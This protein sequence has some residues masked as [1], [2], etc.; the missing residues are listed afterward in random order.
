[1]LQVQSKNRSMEEKTM[2]DLNYRQVHLDFHT[3]QYITEIGKNFDAEKFADTLQKA[4]VNSVT[5]FARCHHGLLYYPSRENPELIHPHLKRPGLL[6]EQIEACHKRGIRVPV[7]TTVRW[8]ER[9]L[10]E[11]PEWL[12]RDPEGNPINRGGTQ[13]SHFCY[14]I[15]LN[16]G[17]REFFK[18]HLMDI[19]DV[20]G[21]ENLDGLFMDIVMQT[22]CCCENCRQLMKQEGLN[23]DIRKDRIRFAELTL[24]R[25][26]SEISAFIR[27]LAPDAS[28]FYNDPGIDPV[29]KRSIDTYSHLELESLPSGDWGY[30]HFPAM[31]RYASHFGKKMIGMTGKFHTAWGDFHSLK[32]KEA[33]E[34]E[35]FQMLAMGTGCSVGDQLHPWG[36]LS[37]AT[38][39]LIG[40]V[41]GRIEAKEP[42]CKGAVMEAEAAVL[43]PHEYLNPLLDGRELP[44]SL[45]GAVH[46]LQELSCQFTV[47]DSKDRFDPYK[48]LILPD[49]IPYSSE[50][51]QKLKDYVAG[52]GAVFGSYHACVHEKSSLYGMQNI[53]E[54][55][56]SREFILPGPVIGKELPDEPFVMYG[57]GTDVEPA[58][59]I[60]IMQKAKPWFE[61]KG[62]KFCS[63]LHAP[64]GDAAAGTEMVQKGNV[65]YCAHPIF[66]IYREY[67][68]RWCREIF[69]DA[70]NILC[71]VRLVSH[72]GPS[73]VQCILNRKDNDTRIL[74]I[75]FYIPE[76]RS[77]KIYTV[78]DLIPLYHLELRVFSEG[79]HVK[80]IRLVPEGDEIPFREEEGNAVFCIEKLS[81]HQMVEIKY[82]EQEGIQDAHNEME[83]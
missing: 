3:S 4:H 62:K 71:P 13:E 15:C 60:C 40:D 49:E 31:A 43:T 47:I 6:L 14:D 12:C 17:Y 80:R 61:R 27:E 65:I 50:L 57:R 46:M 21:R 28:I 79:R 77:E 42:F 66:R 58:D 78:E 83:K 82:T 59:G 75:L 45:I 20:T 34:F 18:K 30:D 11:K 38:Y 41:Y 32:N 53:Q 37:D 54:S 48:V 55:E 81:G 2:E 35:C 5:C 63:H 44:K 72:T 25:F 1:M 16:S 73:G 68:P 74:H 10:R 67:A 7:Y 29:M 8:D 33:L 9:I 56:Y 23:A 52:G 26:R 22:E 69:K 76:K 70:M 39:Q 64:V 36:Q 51:E 24:N 19:I